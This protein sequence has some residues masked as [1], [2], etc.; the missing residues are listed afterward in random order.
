MV[1]TVVILNHQAAGVVVMDFNVM[2]IIETSYLN[3]LCQFEALSYDK[4]T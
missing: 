2:Y 3:D 1:G 4:S